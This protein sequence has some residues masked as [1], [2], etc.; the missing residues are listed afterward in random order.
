MTV[1]PVAGMAARRARE[2]SV[3]TTAASAP[4]RRRNTSWLT[5]PGWPASAWAV[6]SGAKM[7]AN[8]D[9]APKLAPGAVTTKYSGAST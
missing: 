5:R 4:G 2:T 9:S 3:C 7:T 1:K 8:V 6:G